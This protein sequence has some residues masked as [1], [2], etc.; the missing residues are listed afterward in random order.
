MRNRNLQLFA[1]IKNKWIKKNPDQV[2]DKAQLVCMFKQGLL[3]GKEYD[4]NGKSTLWQAASD[5]DI[6]FKQ[7]KKCPHRYGEKMSHC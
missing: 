1:S 6:L 2:V 5:K 4:S 7:S 3:E